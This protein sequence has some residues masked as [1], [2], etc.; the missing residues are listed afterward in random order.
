ME[1]IRLHGW[2]ETTFQRLAD[3]VGQVV[4]I[5][6]DAFLRL[7][8]DVLLV[9]LLQDLHAGDPQLI[10]LDV[11]GVRFFVAVS[12]EQLVK[13]RNWLLEN[14]PMVFAQSEKVREGAIRASLAQP[15]SHCLVPVQLAASFSLA[16]RAE[17]CCPAIAPSKREKIGV[18]INLPQSQG[19]ILGSRLQQ[20][21][22]G[23]IPS[24]NLG[25]ANV[26]AHLDGSMQNGSH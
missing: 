2:S 25:E 16:V 15:D 14:Q 12:V 5:V 18:V 8:V 10:A 13:R 7:R 24:N 23:E 17:T 3:C 4:K 22:H 26:A 1:G 11:E 19:V 9:Q 6:E 20:R 21:S